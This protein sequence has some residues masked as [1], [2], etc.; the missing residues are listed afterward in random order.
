MHYMCI[1][2]ALNVYNTCL[3]YCNIQTLTDLINQRRVLILANKLDTCFTNIKDSR[4]IEASPHST[5]NN[6]SPASNKY[7]YYRLRDREDYEAIVKQ[8]T[9]RYIQEKIGISVPD[10]FIH[11]CMLEW[12]YVA[13]QQYEDGEDCDKQRQQLIFWKELYEPYGELAKTEER[14]SDGKDLE[15]AEDDE[16]KEDVGKLIEQISGIAS[17]EEW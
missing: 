11:P 6:S 17:I 14:E 2:H 5:F 13:R 7:P 4:S 15:E 3:S 9:Q 16:G 12:T 8:R 1:K 10:S